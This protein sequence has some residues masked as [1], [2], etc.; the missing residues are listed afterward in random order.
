MEDL[1]QKV[2]IIGGDNIISCCIAHLG[3]L[4]LAPGVDIEAELTA[5][6]ADSSASSPA[7]SPADDKDKSQPHT[8]HEH[9]PRTLPHNEVTLLK[10][11]ASS[12]FKACKPITDY[13]NIEY[14]S[15]DDDFGPE[16]VPDIIT[17]AM[18]DLSLGDPA[19]RFH[20]KSSSKCL[21]CNDFYSFIICDFSPHPSGLTLV[22]AASDLRKQHG[23]DAVGTRR[24][25]FWTPGD[26]CHYF[27]VRPRGLQKSLQIL[28]GS[29]SLW[30]TSVPQVR[31][32]FRR[33]ILQPLSSSSFS[34]ISV[35]FSPLFI[36]LRLRLNIRTDS[37]S[38]IFHLPWSCYSCARLLPDIA[39][40]LECA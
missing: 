21:L 24:A 31:S 3:F 30:T 20:G 37:I 39:T 25:E 13:D 7:G 14:E 33:K 38:E 6:A 4:Q 22:R 34:A 19:L 27:L 9:S 28:S 16:Q 15:S 23:Y 26:V 8:R 32:L 35:L 36:D 11:Y 18:Q 17:D 12:N 1:L 40:I 29:G 10:D 2:A 5:Q